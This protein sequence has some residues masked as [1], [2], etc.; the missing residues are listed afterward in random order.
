TIHSFF[1]IPPKL[2]SS[3][4]LN[5]PKNHS[6]IK[7]LDTIVIDEISMVRA[8]IIDHINYILQGVKH[9]NN[10]FGGVQMVFFGDMFQLPPVVAGQFEKQYFR[11]FYSSP[12]FFSAK[13]MEGLPHFET[14]ELKQVFRQSQQFFINLLDQIRRDD[15][16]KE[17]Y[18]VLNE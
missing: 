14:Y 12:Y 2:I 1:S 15:A 17:T 18:E 9:N 5:R 10:F 3:E 7:K 6:L 13:C 16:D 4:E 8:D 11:E